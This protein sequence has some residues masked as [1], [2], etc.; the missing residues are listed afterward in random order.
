MLEQLKTM[1]KRWKTEKGI[2]QANDICEWL[3]ANLN[4]ENENDRD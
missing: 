3:V 4:L 1:L 2:D